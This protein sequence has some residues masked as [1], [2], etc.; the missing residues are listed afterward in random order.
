MKNSG[1][2]RDVGKVKVRHILKLYRGNTAADTLM[3][4][5][6]IDSIYNVLKGGADFATVASATTDDPSGKKNGGALPWFGSG[7]MIP[8]FERVAY[9]LADGQMSEP[10]ATSYGFHIVLKES[11]KMVGSLVEEMEAIDEMIARDARGGMG[12][13]AKM[14]QLSAES[15]ITDVQKL[16][17]Y[18]IK[19]LRESNSEFSNLLNEYYDGILLYEISDAEVWGKAN[20][21]VAGLDAYFKT[22]RSDFSWDKPRFKGYLLMAT[23]D[24]VATAAREFVAANNTVASDSLQLMLRRKFGNDV[25]FERVLAPQDS[26]PVIDYVGFGG[27]RPKPMGVWKAFVPCRS[28]IVAQPEDYTDVK[29]LVSVEYQHE[30]EKKWLDRLRRTYK[31]KINDKALNQIR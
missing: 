10:V 11:H 30:L 9:A 28:R 25:R 17:A 1:E 23:S 3:V 12:R 21:D 31:V 20:S 18:A 14:R 19:K 8:D 27:P 5:H 16:D 7:A 4:K 26:S 22:H 29:G 13:A 2:R 15:G 24:S 6:E